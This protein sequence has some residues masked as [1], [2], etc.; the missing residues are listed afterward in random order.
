MTPSAVPSLANPA[1]AASAPRGRVLEIEDPLNHYLYHPLANRLARLLQPTG[2][3]P[4]MVSVASGSLVCA[5]AVFYTQVG[6]PVGV[7]AGFACHL[8]WHVAD[9]AD[10]DLA[11]LTGKASPIGEFIDGAADYLGHIFMYVLLAAMLDE[12]FVGLWAWPLAVLSGISRIAQSNH[13]ETKRRQYLW[14]VYGIP[15]LG[16][17]RDT[18]TP[19]FTGR[20]WFARNAARIVRGYLALGRAT[21]PCSGQLDRLVEEAGGNEERRAEVRARIRSASHG[22]LSLQKAL[23]ANPRTIL[24]GLSM[25]AGTPLWF[26]LIEGVALNVLLAI[27]VSYHN[28]VERRLLTGLSER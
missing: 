15:W 10:G 24:L 16:T 1:P 27:S 13:A 11:R 28:G 25:I 2:V 23:G 19:A 5:A 12:T 21:A 6:W 14:R 7:L 4:N 18:A 22:S 8:M 9:G 26:F 3:S 17:Q 20:G